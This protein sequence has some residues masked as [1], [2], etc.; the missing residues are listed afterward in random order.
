M[1]E[2]FLIIEK[3]LGMLLLIGS[4]CVIG[5]SLNKLFNKNFDGKR[6]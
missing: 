5:Y 4:F 1:N 2:T 6:P 3:I